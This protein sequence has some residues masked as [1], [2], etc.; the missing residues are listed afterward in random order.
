MCKGDLVTW[1]RI[2]RNQASQLPKAEGREGAGVH[3][4]GIRRVVPSD[5]GSQALM[6]VRAFGSTRPLDSKQTAPW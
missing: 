6:T 4:Q 3:L 5:P 2:K 1:E